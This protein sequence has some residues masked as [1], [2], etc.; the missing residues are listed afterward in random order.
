MD[1]ISRQFSLTPPS[2]FLVVINE[3][4]G[5]VFF[6]LPPILPSVTFAMLK[7]GSG[8]EEKNNYCWT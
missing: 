5:V 1:S 7:S 2:P 6:T 4:A 3:L 8:E